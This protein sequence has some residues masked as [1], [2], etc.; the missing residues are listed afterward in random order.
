[1][2][3][4]YLD[5]KL[6]QSSDGKLEYCNSTQVISILSTFCSHLPINVYFIISNTKKVISFEEYASQINSGFTFPFKCYNKVSL[7]S[8]DDLPE[9]ISAVKLPAIL[10]SCSSYIVCGLCQVVRHLVIQGSLVDQSLKKL[11]GY[12]FSCFKTSSEVSSRGYLCEVL[13]A[14]YLDVQSLNLSRESSVN[15]PEVVDSFE[16]LLSKPIR[17]HNRDKRQR[18]ILNLVDQEIPI[19]VRK[20]NSGKDEKMR[21]VVVDTN[22]LPSLEHVF[23]DGVD[24]MVSDISLIP[25]IHSFLTKCNLDEAHEKIPLVI[26]WY[27]QIQLVNGVPEAFKQCKVQFCSTISTPKSFSSIKSSDEKYELLKH[28]KVKDEAVP[29]YVKPLTIKKDLKSVL[30]KVGTDV[31]FE[32]Y[33]Q[34]NIKLSWNEMPNHVHPISGDLKSLR[35]TRKQQQIENLVQGCRNVSKDG[36][37]IVEFCCGG[38]HVGIVLAYL[39][40]SCKVILLDN[41]EESL[42]RAHARV[43]AL[44]LTNVIIYQCNLDHYKGRFDVGVALHACGVATDMVLQTCL[45][46][47]AS[48]VLAPCCYGKI[49]ETDSITYPQ[50]LKMMNKSIG[51][52]ELLLLGQA[53][54]QTCWQFETTKAKTGKLCMGLV[55]MDRCMAAEQLNYQTNLL[56]MQPIVCTPKNNLI[57]GKSPFN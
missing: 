33:D 19:K 32:E 37:V 56:T 52:D 49:H 42:N 8:Y 28:K 54:D 34:N 7:T 31:R 38:G 40:P 53:A 3:S 12:K 21:K 13:A 50:S 51:Y 48:F 35:A 18:K 16:K 22:D 36:D 26:K 45:S 55:D 15:L 57:I 5:G 43:K 41:K 20:T 24:F 9:V 6:L 1:M 14:R 47:E 44:K 30:D 27:H 17:I 29:K 39:M 23:A 2:E 25:C 46:K 10:K 11:L 4:L